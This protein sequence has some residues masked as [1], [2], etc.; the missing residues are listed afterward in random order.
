MMQHRSRFIVTLLLSG[1]GA[2]STL[3]YQQPIT[4]FSQG[5]SDLNSA[6][7]AL[8]VTRD[9]AAI[10]NLANSIKQQGTFLSP[11][12][13]CPITANPPRDANPGDC[14]WT[15]HYP[16]GSNLAANVKNHEAQSLAFISALDAYGQGLVAISTAQDIAALKTAVAK[17]GSAIAS[18]SSLAM[19]GSGTAVNSITIG[20][21]W[22]FGEIADAERLKTLV[23][24]VEKAD[25]VIQKETALLQ[26]SA[27]HLQ[28]E[29]LNDQQYIIY[30]EMAQVSLLTKSNSN[31]SD[32]NT[33]AQNVVNDAI[34]YD[35]TASNDIGSALVKMKSSHADLLKSLKN[36]D[37]NFENAISTASDFAAQ[38]STL[39]IIEKGN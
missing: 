16:G 10:N 15:I 34:A 39:M 37:I 2:C 29:I 36:P 6:F 32:I 12:T 4:Q 13:G 24:I 20:F 17:A 8:R 14:S 38:A 7:N 18:V 35:K 25:P 1:V 27:E 22:L 21:A 31:Y 28:A 9:N 5:V 30:S 19:P 3:N 33:A 23:A 11:P 26:K